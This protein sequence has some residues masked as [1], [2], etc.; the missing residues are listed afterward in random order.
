MTQALAS[1]QT[2]QFAIKVING[3]EAGAV[4]EF[5][6]G[7]V[8]IGRSPE[9]DIVFGHDPKVSRKHVV[10]DFDQYPV[11]IKDVTDKNFILIDGV[12]VKNAILESVTQVQVGDMEIEITSFNQSSSADH[13]SEPLA[14][15][16]APLSRSE[17][18]IPIPSPTSVAPA[19]PPV[20]ETSQQASTNGPDVKKKSGRLRFYLIVAAIG[21]LFWFLLAGENKKKEDPLKIRTSE[22]IMKETE[23]SRERHK[24]ILQAKKKKGTN[25]R[26][27]DEAQSSYVRCFRDYRQGQY[28]RA[29]QHC[30]AALSLYPQHE[31]AE[32]Y[33]S[34]AKRRRDEKTQFLL[35]EGRMHRE[36]GYYKNCMSTLRAVMYEIR[37]PKNIIFKEASQLYSECL[38][39]S[40]G[41]F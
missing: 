24:A 30:Q 38:A 37:D 22:E 19:P 3:P 33:M 31:L 23:A 8:S 1:S 12:Q 41:R 20:W 16:E 21:G 17:W 6:G 35:R 5:S 11:Q 27:F 9:N 40:E 39:L 2:A 7:K 14:P 4:Y 36:R 26:Q 25:T 13:V 29:M 15:E 34:L 28:T 32:R 10:I 18:D